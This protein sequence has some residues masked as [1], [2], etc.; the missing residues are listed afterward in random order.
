MT[1]LLKTSVSLEAL[2]TARGVALTRGREQ[3]RTADPACAAPE[4]P[5]DLPLPAPGPDGLAPLA[6]AL[7]RD[8]AA[9][10][11]WP[12]AE[13]ALQVAVATVRQGPADGAAGTE[14]ERVIGW[15]RPLLGADPRLPAWSRTLLPAPGPSWPAGAIAAIA[16]AASETLPLPDAE[17]GAG[18]PAVLDVFVAADLVRAAAAAWLATGAP[19]REVLSPALDVDDPGFALEPLAG[20]TDA[21]GDPVVALAAVRAGVVRELPGAAGSMVCP[22]WRDRPERGWR[23]LRVRAADAAW[24]GTADVVTRLVPAGAV[25]LAFGTR[26][27]D[28][29]PVAR[30]GGIPLGSPAAWLRAVTAQCGPAVPDGAGVPVAVAP[31]LVER[32]P[33]RGAPARGYSAP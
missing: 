6:A 16:R 8:L 29:R 1:A 14:S 20:E 3:G 33:W 11:S 2:A 19:G 10:V 15:L 12:A 26:W 31:L 25:V 28:G 23:S 30:F 17:P 24:P 7:R 21:A 4:P 27:S 22:G 5:R 32:P 9:A 13:V 18:L